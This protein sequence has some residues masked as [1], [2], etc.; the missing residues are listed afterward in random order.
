VQTRLL[1]RLTGVAPGLLQGMFD[2]TVRKA[3][4]AHK[5]FT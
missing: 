1:A 4:Q 5:Q 2:R 3:Q